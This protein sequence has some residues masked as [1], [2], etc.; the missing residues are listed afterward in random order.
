MPLASLA[1]TCDLAVVGAGP[2]GMAT[3]A[4][5]AV[6]GLDTVL[7]DEQAAP[8]GEVYR[9]VEAVAQ[10]RPGALDALGAGYAKGLALAAR[11]RAS[12]ARYR[13]Q[14]AVWAVEENGAPGA[15]LGGR[16]VSADQ[17]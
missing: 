6:L 15:S 10:A 3:A 4:Q 11:F 16:T 7:I 12:G 13:P 2:A 14:T 8:G 9:N 17:K 1:A 5:A